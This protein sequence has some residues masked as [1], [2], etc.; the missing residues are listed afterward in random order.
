MVN[1]QKYVAPISPKAIAASLALVAKAAHPLANVARMSG[2]DRHRLVKLKRGAQQVFPTIA[3][4]ASKFALEVPGSSVADMMS[5]I[6]HAR[7]LEPLLGAVSDLHEALRDEYLRAQSEAWSIATVTYGVLRKAAEAN[8]SI[9][10][11][12][13]P[14]RAW[15]RYSNG[16]K[17][18]KV[19]EPAAPPKPADTNPVSPSNGGAA[20]S[21]GAAT[22]HAG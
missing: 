10:T 17:A 8:H 22:S 9:R 19:A 1:T 18:A 15:F 2:P 11:E 14:V 21:N 4:V 20:G 7:E 6:A 12:I 3:H 5:K 16:R 13:A